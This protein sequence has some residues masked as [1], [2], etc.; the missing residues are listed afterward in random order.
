MFIPVDNSN[1]DLAAHVHAE[2]WRASHRAFCSEEFVA[3]HTDARQKEYLKRKLAA[4]GKLFMLIVDEPVGIVCVAGNLIEDLYVLPDR[5][6]KGYGS[7]LLKYAISQCVGAPTLWIL[8]SNTGA[9]RLYRRMGFKKT[10]N[11]RPHP[12]GIDEIEYSL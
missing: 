10:G 3:A 1:I 5:Q 11:V 6:N 8:E 7:E 9:E 4:G 2:S 12:N